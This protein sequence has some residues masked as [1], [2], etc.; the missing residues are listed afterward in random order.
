MSYKKYCDNGY[1]LLLLGINF[2][3]NSP[4]KSQARLSL[5][6]YHIFGPVKMLSSSMPELLFATIHMTRTHGAAHARAFLE[7]CCTVDVIDVEYLML[8]AERGYAI[9]TSAAIK[10]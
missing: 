6:L 1:K 10:H 5:V 9:A 3:T 8:M 2:L 4:Q 7:D